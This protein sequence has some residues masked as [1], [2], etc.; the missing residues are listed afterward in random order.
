M[1]TPSNPGWVTGFTP[2]AQQWAAEWSSK[3]DYPATLDQGGTSATTAAGAA[4]SITQRALI[5]STP[6]NLA[7]L[8]S[9]GVRTSVGAFSLYLPLLASLIPGD[10]IDI[11]DVD[12]NANVNN[13]SVVGNTSDQIALYATNAGTQVLSIAGVKVRLVV[14][15]GIWR[16]LI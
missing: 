13:I 2:T 5:A 1:A 11:A 14:N 6:F 15:A 16:M 7:P 4:Y 9:Y 8:T 10:W 12:F 3:V